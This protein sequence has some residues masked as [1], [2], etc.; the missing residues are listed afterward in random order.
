MTL[1]ID[2]ENVILGVNFYLNAGHN[3]NYRFTDGTLYKA[4]SQ[5]YNLGPSV[6]IS[7]QSLRLR[8]SYSMNLQVAKYDL[9]TI[10]DHNEL[11]IKLENY[12]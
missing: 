5:N 11:K 4:T 7:N 6:N 10:K 1:K 9:E 8:L 2:T 3:K 12:L